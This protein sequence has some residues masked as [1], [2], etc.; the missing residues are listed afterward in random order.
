M[1]FFA[2]VAFTI[3]FVADGKDKSTENDADD[4]VCPCGGV[5]A[6]YA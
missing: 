5:A 6:L 1:M 4:C 3:V 2:S